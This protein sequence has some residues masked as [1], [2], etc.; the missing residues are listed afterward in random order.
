MIRGLSSRR[1]QQKI[2]PFNLNDPLILNLMRISCRLAVHSTALR[3]LIQVHHVHGAQAGLLCD[4]DPLM[5]WKRARIDET[6]MYPLRIV[7]DVRNKVAWKRLA[8]GRLSKFFSSPSLIPLT[9]LCETF[10]FAPLILFSF[11]I[12]S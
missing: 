10:F 9:H 11:F 5:A 2:I 6:I 8:S 7:G 12:P 4:N 3:V 1:Q